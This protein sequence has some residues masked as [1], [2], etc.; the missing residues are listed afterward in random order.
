MTLARGARQLV[1]QDALL[2]QQGNSEVNVSSTFP[3]L[4]H[5][6]DML[7]GL[8]LWKVRIGM[9]KIT[10]DACSLKEAL[11]VQLGKLPK[12]IAFLTVLGEC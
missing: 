8:G 2:T 9:R 1:V 12:H 6:G 4:P 7:R 10:G 11:E 3:P 5:W